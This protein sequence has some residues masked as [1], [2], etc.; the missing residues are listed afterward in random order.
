MDRLIAPARK[1]SN[2]PMGLKKNSTHEVAAGDALA[3][4]SSIPRSGMIWELM[5]K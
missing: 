5:K 1:F 2:S 3:V 4:N